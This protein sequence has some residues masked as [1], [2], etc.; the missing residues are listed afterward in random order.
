[1]KPVAERFWAKVKI[2]DSCW[3]WTA[4]RNN[5]GY[6]T[7]NVGGR[8]KLAHRVAY[9]LCVG[10]I[11]DRM[12]LDHL[13]HNADKQCQGGPTCPHRSCVNPAHLEPTSRTINTI[14]GRC[15]QI[16][17]ARHKSKT[18]C[19]KGHPY[20]AANTAHKQN[21]T[22]RVCIECRRA[23]MRR[24]QAKNHPEAWALVQVK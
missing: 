15:G 18:Q 7:I 8:P 14:R 20:D 24:W 6:G 12:E 5:M 2:S 11:P 4:A 1:M 16:N 22:S 23:R 19:P 3:H 21:G 10:A 13:C 17:R 9:T